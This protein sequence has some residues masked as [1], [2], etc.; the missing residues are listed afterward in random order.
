M[1]S[2]CMR[3]RG[4]IERVARPKVVTINQYHHFNRD[5]RR[6]QSTLAPPYSERVNKA[7]IWM[8]ATGRATA[9]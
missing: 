1:K 5:C 7:L 9:T 6:R 4:E 8:D 3:S 2:E